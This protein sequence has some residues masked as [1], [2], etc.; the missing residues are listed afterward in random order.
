MKKV[1]LTTLQVAIT[2]G[3]LW[4]VFRDPAKRAEMFVALKG[5]N[6]VWLLVG[7]AV[8][9]VVELAAGI[10]WQLL[11][12]VQGIQ[13]RWTRVFMLMMIG[14]FF[15]FFVPGGTG[16]DV[17]KVFYLLKE[18]PG[19]GAQA[20]LSV[21]V[22][23][24]I[25]LL[26]LIALAGVLIAMRWDWLLASPETAKYVWVTLAVLASAVFGI[27][28]SF[29]ISG[30]GLVHKL[31]ARLPGRDKAAELAMA[32]NLYGRA[33]RPTIGSFLMS[34]AAHYGY[35][36][37]FY[38]AARAFEAPGVR[39]PTLGELC[40]IMPIVN[41]IV[42]MPI[43]FGGIGVRE[44]LFQ[45]FLG[46]LAGVSESV[47]VVISSTGYLITLMWGLFG[48]VLYMIYRP[49]KHPKLREMRA[50]VGAFEHDVAAQE[51]AIELAEES[52]LARRK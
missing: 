35:F 27:G 41:T 45:I 37:T 42:S 36:V 52:D 4:I 13:L 22:D 15:N 47:A 5:A 18:T 26:S 1:A 8:Y 6:P 24:I 12:R 39:I 48:G 9:G 23:R 16:G 32:Y 19:R 17:V 29:V 20:L 34:V 14:I 3:I 10:R 21:L 46:N 38:C 28:V 30:F 40:A 44:G 31:P 49:S 50:E 11:L 7:L 25:G 51:I 33:W 43:S 2:L